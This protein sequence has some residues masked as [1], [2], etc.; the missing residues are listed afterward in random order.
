MK[1]M[2][3]P[4]AII[5]GILVILAVMLVPKY[6]T[7]VGLEEDVD[8]SYSQIENQLQRRMDLIPNLV[9]SVKGF[10]KHEEKVLGDIADARSRLAGANTPEEQATAND[11]LSGAL[12]RLLVV[13]ENY[14]ELKADANFR[15]LM[16]ELAGTENRIGVARMDYNDTVSEYNRNVRRFPGSLVAGIFG[17][18]EKEYFKAAAGAQEAPKVD[19]G[20]FGD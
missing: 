14:P 8:K 9:E 17:F 2:F 12:S 13:V 6:N 3:G 16:D 1:R 11:E 19:F 4:I 20:E 5:I 15:Q 18:D 10:A 7:L